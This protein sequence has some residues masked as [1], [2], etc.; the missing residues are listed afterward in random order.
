M[1]LPVARYGLINF[2]YYY[3]DEAVYTF[4]EAHIY[5][6]RNSYR[7][8]PYHRL[9][10][11]INFTKQKK[12]GERIWNISIYNVYN[13]KNPYYIFLKPENNIYKLYQQSLFPIIP[14]ISYSFKF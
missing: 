13:R 8:P 4:D 10:I 7:L 3:N 6:G 5:Q 1:T 12:R 14:S 9:D 11:G 2:N